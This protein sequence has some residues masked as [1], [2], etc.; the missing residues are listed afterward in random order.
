MIGLKKKPQSFQI[1]VRNVSE[2]TPEAVA[3]SGIVFDTP[4]VVVNFW[5][6]VIEARADYEP[7]K[8]RLVAL[9]LDARLR[10]KAYNLV[11][12]GSLNEAVVHPREVLRPAIVIAAF[13]LIVIHNHPS[14]DPE[15]SM[16]DRNMTRELSEASRI[17]KI[18]LFD[19]VIIGD[20]NALNGH[21]SFRSAG[22]L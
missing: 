6:T 3:Y 7:E 16:A 2:P 17:M 18:T 5:R 21:Y 1:V 12:L 15:P 22:L 14:G 4:E 20:L 13:G 8:E 9:L 11:S 10:L 19:H